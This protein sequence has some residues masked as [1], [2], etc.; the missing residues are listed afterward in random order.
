MIGS[1]PS[2]SDDEEQQGSQSVRYHG[3]RIRLFTASESPPRPSQPSGIDS[4]QIRATLLAFRLHKISGE[5]LREIVGVH[6][7]LAALDPPLSGPPL[8]VALRAY[9]KGRISIEE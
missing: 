8:W 6:A 1:S 3:E 2:C 5:E 4:A 9:N 7:R